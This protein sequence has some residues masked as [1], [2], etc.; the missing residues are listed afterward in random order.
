M[1]RQIKRDLYWNQVR[2]I[3]LTIIQS[4]KK[5]D[6]RSVNEVLNKIIEKNGVQVDKNV[7]LQEK[8]KTILSIAEKIIGS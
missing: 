8:T 5:D 1:Y 3:C 4:Q 7:T 2:Q 6:D